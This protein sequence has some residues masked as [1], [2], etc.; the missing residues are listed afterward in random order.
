MKVKTSFSE[1]LHK[2]LE[3]DVE[4]VVGTAVAALVKLIQ[5]DREILL[6]EA[7]VKQIQ[8]SV[9]HQLRFHMEAIYQAVETAETAGETADDLLKKSAQSIEARAAKLQYLS[10]FD[11]V[12]LSRDPD[13]ALEFLQAVEETV[14]KEAFTRLQE[15][16]Q[17]MWY[18]WMEEV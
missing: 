8:D 12:T 16:R 14:F 15:E 17:H 11:Q 9:F 18:K 7:E 10:A 6:A 4:T 3:P 1:E 2:R 5:R 13:F